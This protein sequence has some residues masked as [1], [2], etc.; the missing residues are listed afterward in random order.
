M[1]KIDLVYHLGIEQE[2]TYFLDATVCVN[3]YRRR[4]NCI[5]NLRSALLINLGTGKEY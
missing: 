3:Q 1:D 2:E 5:S 4:K